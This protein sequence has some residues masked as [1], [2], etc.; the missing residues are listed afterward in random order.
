MTEGNQPHHTIC[1]SLSKQC[2]NAIF[3]SDRSTHIFGLIISTVTF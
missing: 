1:T 2:T 3:C